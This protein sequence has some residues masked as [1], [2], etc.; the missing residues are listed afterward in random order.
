MKLTITHARQFLE[1]LYGRFFSQAQG[2]AYLEVRGKREGEG[3]SFRRF[4]PLT[5]EALVKDMGRWQ[6]GLHYW[7][8]VALRRDNQG[9]KKSNLLAMTAAFA[10]V[11]AG[12]EGHK[13]ATSYH[14]K[15]EALA[16]IQGFALRPSILV[17]SGGGFQ[18]YWLF[19]EPV[20]LT[21]ETIKRLEKINRGLALALGGDLA[22]TDASRILRLP[23][24]FNMKIPGQPRPV[25]IVWCKPERVYDLADFAP[26]EAQAKA[27]R[28]A[29]LGGPPGK[30]AGIGGDFARY[31]EKALNDELAEL[32]QTPEGSRNARLNQAAFALGQLVGAGV[33]SRERVEAALSDT[34]AGIGLE[35]AESRATIRSGLDSGEQ[36]PRPLPERTATG[37]K[38]P[39]QGKPSASP[40]K[41]GQGAGDEAEPERKWLCGHGYFVER[42]RL[43]LEMFGKQGEPQPRTLANFSARIEAEITLDD[44]LRATKEFEV[45]GALDTGRPLPVARVGAEKFDGL[46]WV[47]REWGAAATIA[48]GRSLGPH[49]ATA[50]SAFSKDF[51]RRTVYAHTGW[52]K[53]GGAWRYLHGGG[54]I[55]PGEPVEVALGENLHCYRLPAPGGREAAQASC[56][57]LEVAPWE[58]TAPLLAAVYLA[59]FADLLKIDFSLWLHGPTGAMKSTLAALALCHFGEFSRLTLPGSWFSTA[60]ALERLCFIL[61]DCL[62]V[63]DDFSPAASARDFTHQ[64]EKAGRLIYQAGNRSGRGRLAPDLSARPNYYPRG[65]ILSTGETLLPGQRQSATARYL[66]VELDPKKNPI[67]RERL[68]AAQREAGLYAAA[69][70]AYLADLAQRLDE[71]QEELKGLFEIYRAAFQKGDHARIPKIL[72]WLACGFN[73]ALRFFKRL[74]A[75]SEDQEYEFEKKAWVVW[76]RLGQQHS[77]VIEGER[78]TAKFL[79][80]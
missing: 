79:L 40:E 26:Y 41:G 68:S 15:D 75:I 22:A 64:A 28:Q 42:G 37:G 60:N 52:R 43:T 51:R 21:P 16:V 71:A 19:Q 67:D 70:A 29:H 49:L 56:R 11:D 7:V 18:P 63:V 77:R 34:A 8:G 4:Y 61:K 78:P 57:F 27:R 50:I 3:M 54:A 1:A 58:V 74:G 47:K 32:A 55:G 36:N 5:P 2:T 46:A 44:G 65:L 23:G 35:E 30:G 53:I 72:S 69:M 31:G 9:G 33:L 14:T 13:A 80:Y 25:V 73:L 24:T 59:P 17:D 12:A 48:P 76:E 20:S 10:D 39:R 38:A 62:V 6:P 45:T 66:G